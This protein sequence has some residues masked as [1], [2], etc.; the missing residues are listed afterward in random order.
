MIVIVM[1]DVPLKLL[2]EAEG[3]DIN[4]AEKLKDYCEESGIE[5]LGEVIEDKEEENE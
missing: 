3:L 2:K 5:Y 4:V 1:V